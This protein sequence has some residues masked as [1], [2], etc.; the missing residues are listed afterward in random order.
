MEYNLKLSVE[1]RFW[2]KVDKSG[3]PDAC[4]PWTKT[5]NMGGYGQFSVRHRHVLAH[6]M[7]FLLSGGVIPSDLFVLHRCDNPPC[8]NPKHLFIGTN[9]DNVLDR[10][11]KNRQPR[12]ELIGNSKLS[13]Q[14]VVALKMLRSFGWRYGTLS[15]FF[16]I[17]H[18]QVYRICRGKSRQ[19]G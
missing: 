19:N 11:N 13:N 12:G 15:V 16:G 9:A 2:Q 14:K 17:S 18:N 8:C 6:R 4:W 10:D 3:G 1:D 7:S 5:R